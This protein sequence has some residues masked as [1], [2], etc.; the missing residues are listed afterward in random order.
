MAENLVSNASPRQAPTAP[1]R[2]KEEVSA[3]SSRNEKYSA[4]VTNKAA[5]FSF[6][7]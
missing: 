5:R 6:V 2:P 1:A 7:T 4:A 3:R